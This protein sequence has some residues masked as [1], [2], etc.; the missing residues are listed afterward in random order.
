[1]VANVRGSTSRYWDSFSKEVRFFGLTRVVL[2]SI[3][4]MLGHLLLLHNFRVAL[5]HY[6]TA[7]AKLVDVLFKFLISGVGLDEFEGRVDKQVGGEISGGLLM[8]SWGSI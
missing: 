3:G 1:M 2:Y 6:F 7:L 5:H 4:D 8:I